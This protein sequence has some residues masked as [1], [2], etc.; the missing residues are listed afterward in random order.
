MDEKTRRGRVGAARKRKREASIAGKAGRTRQGRA[1]RAQGPR[2]LASGSVEEARRASERTTGSNSSSSSGSNGSSN[3]GGGSN[4]AAAATRSGPSRENGTDRSERARGVE[5]ASGG[6]VGWT[7]AE[8]TDVAPVVF[9][10][11]K[12]SSEL[13]AGRIPQLE[14]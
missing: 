10:L 3:G 1:R 7:L 14:S 5:E 12:T 4:T 2:A 8:A 11:L 13:G 9:Y 6:V